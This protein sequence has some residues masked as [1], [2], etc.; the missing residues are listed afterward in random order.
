MSG[1]LKFF[2]VSLCLSVSV[3]FHLCEKVG[4]CVLGVGW[5]FFRW[6]SRC[7]TFSRGIYV[8]IWIQARTHAHTHTHAPGFVSLCIHFNSQQ[9][10]CAVKTGGRRRQ[11]SYIDV[12]IWGN[13]FKWKWRNDVFESNCSLTCLTCFLHLKMDYVYVWLKKWDDVPLLSIRPY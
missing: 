7:C 1:Y 8:R 3:R 11:T 13:Q 12:P 4:C 5:W 10:L 2:G 6:A 9:H